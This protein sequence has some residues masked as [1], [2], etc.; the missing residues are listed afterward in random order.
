MEASS[1]KAYTK[2]LIGVIVIALIAF[3]II[4]YAQTTFT[5]MNLT[6]VLGFAATLSVVLM[7]FGALLY[8]VD[9]LI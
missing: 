9:K 1:T 6:G 2:E 5:E 8:M 7:T 4:P 3:T